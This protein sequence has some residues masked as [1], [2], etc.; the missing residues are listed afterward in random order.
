MKKLTRILIGM[1]VLCLCAVACKD[2][3]VD[4]DELTDRVEELESG[5]IATISQQIASINNSIPSLQ[6]A[7]NELKVMIENLN[8]SAG[9]LSDAI[10]ANEEKLQNFKGDIDKTIEALREE[11]ALTQSAES[12]ELLDALKAAKAEIE[13]QIA[14]LQE[15]TGK[16]VTQ[17]DSTITVL[18]DKDTALEA[19]IADLKTFVTDSLTSTKKWAEKTFATLE[20]QEA[21]Q[22]ELSAVKG[23]VTS[24]QTSM[25][26]MEQRITENYTK[27]IQEEIGKL[28]SKLQSEFEGKLSDQAKEITDAYTE[29]IAA[30]KEE[31]AEAYTIDLVNAIDTSEK[32]MQ[33]WVN[34]TLTAYLTIADAEERLAA[35]KTDLETQLST[36]KA[37]LE[38]LVNALQED[39]QE[40]DKN[41]GDLIDAN[42]KAIQDNADA[43]QTNADAI[44]KLGEDLE[45]AKKDIETAYKAA[46]KDAVDDVTTAY[47]TAIDNKAKELTDKINNLNTELSGKISDVYKKVSDLTSAV[48]V[49]QNQVDGISDKLDTV[50]DKLDAFISGRVQS[51]SYIPSAADRT[52]TLSWFRNDFSSDINLNFEVRPHS[53]ASKITAD[54]MAVQVKYY[55]SDAAVSTVEFESVSGDAET[56]ILT[57]TV[58]PLKVFP[59]DLTTDA[60]VSVSVQDKTDGYYDVASEYVSVKVNRKYAF[61]VAKTL[62]GKYSPYEMTF[63]NGDVTVPS[64]ES[65][66]GGVIYIDAPKE[67]TRMRFNNPND[68]NVTSISF[69]PAYAGSTGIPMQTG[70]DAV[71]QSDKKLTYVD[72]GENGLRTDEVT[73]FACM[74][75]ECASLTGVDMKYCNTANVTNMQ[76]MFRACSSLKDIDLSTWSTSKVTTVKEMFLNCSSL[77]NIDL[78]AWKTPAL[79]DVTNFFQGCSSLETVSLKG[80]DL[81]NV[82]ITQGMFADCTNLKYVDFTGVKWPKWSTKTPIE[83]TSAAAMFRGTSII[84]VEAP[85]K[86]TLK[87]QRLAE[88]FK[89]CSKLETVNLSG[90]VVMEKVENRKICSLSQ[91]FLNCAVLTNVNLSGWDVH[92][93]QDLREMFKDCPVLDTV[94]LSGWILKNDAYV[95]DMFKNT[96][97]K[98]VILKDSDDKTIQKIKNALPEGA[99]L[100]TE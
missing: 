75:N 64:T 50:S 46:I 70:G 37:Y 23:S 82:T 83:V 77:K 68:D 86:G 73:T 8:K 3:S 7:D 6:T 92:K 63:Y 21:I 28:E 72:F 15:E 100:V 93:V 13:G 1:G 34:R 97:V 27:A 80:W 78:S 14:A 85:V 30:A 38:G 76:Q 47:T 51:I 17:M 90:N 79:T 91:M 43:I 69:G 9:D 74:F 5:K 65:T 71:F 61:I 36:Q 53:M 25:E 29:A 99:E 22:K 19:K 26:E 41:L 54:Q 81:S 18:K 57:V 95:T 89:D 49:L 56:G 84:K 10:S 31:I 42:K 67:A 11:F 66:D 12:K 33:R 20:Q 98:K 94:D 24:L 87:V 59:S 16:K 52:V 48:A 39:M 35:Q 2:Y 40:A 45:Q 62:D 88:M 58:D 55:G 4:I 60:A 44:K 96:P 32:E